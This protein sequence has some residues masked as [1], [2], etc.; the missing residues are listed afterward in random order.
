MSLT[1][2]V[3]KRPILVIVFI[4]LTALAGIMVMPTL[5]RQQYP[6]VDFP[7]ISVAATYPGAST[8]QI[9]DA[10]VRP[11]ED[12]IAGAPNLD[13]LDTT[14]VAGK[15]SISAVFALSS[16]Q[17]ADLLQV[18][19]RVNAAQSQLPSD[20]QTPVVSTVDP[21]QG[22]VISLV[23]SSDSLSPG[24]FSDRLT[25][26]II[27]ALTQLP[28][29]A[30][31]QVSGNVIPSFQVEVDP[32]RLQA[33]GYTL[34]DVLS[35]I[36]NNNVLAPGGLAYASNRE[37]GITVRG[38]I[39][40]PQQVGALLLGGGTASSSA[41]P[42]QNPWTVSKRLFRVNDVASVRDAYEPRR[43]YAFSGSDAIIGLDVTKATGASD[44]ATS[45]AVLAALPQLAKAFPD[46]QMRIVDIE[47]N[48]TKQQVN[49][50]VRSLL[51]A[52]VLTSV[53]MLFFLRSW[54]NAVV[55]LI[56][57]PTSLFVTL[58]VMKLANFTLD[59]V[60]LGAMTLAIGILVDDS[61]VVLEN[62]KR[63]FDDGEDPQTAAIKGRTE[64]GMAAITLTLV[65]VVI[66]LPIA[67]LP[68]II[69]RFLQEFA[70]VVVVATLT[71][72]VVGFTVT[73]AFAGR[74][75]LLS[76]WK[77]PRVIDWF[78]A[79]FERVRR[80]YIGGPLPWALCRGWLVVGIAAITLVLAVGLVPAGLVGFEFIPNG[81]QGNF[82]VQAAYPAGTP[83][84]ATTAG[85][86][87]LECAI[88][89]IADLQAETT[90]S[91]GYQPQFG[92]VINEGSVGQ[93]HVFL[94]EKRNH[95]TD[96][97]T[98]Y[99]QQEARR[100][101]P[102]AS[103]VTIPAAGVTGGP[104]QDIDFVVSQPNGDP[105]TAA[106]RVADALRGIP[107]V[108]AVNSVGT[109]L[110]PQVNVVFDRSRAQ[111]L[112]VNIGTASQAVRA[113]FGGVR[114]TQFT[115]ASGLKYVDVIYPQENQQ[116]LAAIYALPIRSNSGAVVHIDD[117]ANLQY[118]PLPPVMTR[119]DRSVVVHVGAN[120]LPRY[121]L[122]NIQ[123][124]FK[125]RLAAL[126][127]P[128]NVTVA[129]G[130]NGSQSN[131]A[132]LQSGIKFSLLLSF[133]LVYLLMVALYNDF[134][135]PL[136]IMFAVPVTAVGALGSLALMHQTLNLFSMIG[137]VLL[138]GLVIKNSILLVDFADQLRR[139][140]LDKRAAI[141]RSAELR[142]RPIVMTTS[143][144]VVSML[145]IALALE[146]GSQVR[147]ALG[148]VV[149]GGLTSSLLLSLVLV[150][151]VYLWLAPKRVHA[152]DNTSSDVRRAGL[153][154]DG[155]R[156]V[157][158]P[159]P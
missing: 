91:G 150:P 154:T 67:F 104:S 44:I 6:N 126:Q 106:G 133:V 120:V 56:A 80:A 34:T 19:N 65:D 93:I 135:S 101:M 100:V 25:N 110:T 75:S 27:P 157:L 86:R 59:T 122:S 158:T 70:L 32:G 1:A 22:A 132:D 35:A 105:G 57:I 79:A 130:A 111:T 18:Q 36:S 20:L 2:L 102:G 117:I 21:T 68:G 88:N 145:P 62:I 90:I 155:D 124:A 152:V 74:W 60:S 107:G 9:R 77:P 108:Y 73:P 103:V 29:V 97:W 28:G 23:A 11:I 58:A 47:S 89:R 72:L 83:L 12:Q 45:R 127:L 147:R 141:E 14:I 4:L 76:N 159:S 41:I 140:G 82:Y 131:L 146:P 134:R 10:I 128:S 49:G 148:I 87:R 16:D 71:S 92:G 115:D 5:V 54:R 151:V 84:E 136:I 64:I 51:E 142:F 98:R 26:K 96:Y 48:Y 114:A 138:V 143:A 99:V 17:N 42:G 94:K 13:H 123:R 52:V 53:T 156:P 38:D 7:T 149:I 119:Q 63:H 116:D 109:Q 8:S 121:Q 66:F 125:T 144:M 139:T 33:S 129:P 137:L 40:T 55:V 15:A 24:A 61:T 112:N 78:D 113:A 118:A 3:V 50:A 81:D 95:P 37:T 46:V 31:V 30:A 153:P 43:V 85:I 69:G 39:Q